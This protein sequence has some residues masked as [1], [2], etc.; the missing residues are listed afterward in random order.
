MALSPEPVREP[1]PSNVSLPPQISR[2]VADGVRRIVPC[3]IEIIDRE[4]TKQFEREKEKMN[5][6]VRGGG[7]WALLRGL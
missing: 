1:A 7:G 3:N 6:L 4:R 2:K 5:W